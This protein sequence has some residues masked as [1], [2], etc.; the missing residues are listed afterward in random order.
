[1]F[2]KKYFPLITLVEITAGS[3]NTVKEMD[4]GKGHDTKEAAFEKGMKV[5]NTSREN[6]ITGKVY[7][8]Y[9]TNKVTERW[10]NG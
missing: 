4:Y 5:H 8:Y 6:L 7:Q 9:F 10:I 2:V 1:M 3:P